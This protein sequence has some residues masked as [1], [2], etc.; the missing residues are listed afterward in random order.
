[1]KIVYLVLDTG[2]PVR[3]S[4]GASAHVRALSEALAE[5]G[6]EITVVAADIEGSEHLAKE[7]Q[8]VPIPPSDAVEALVSTSPERKRELRSLF[9][10]IDAYRSLTNL[11]RTIQPDVVLERLS[12]FSITGLAAARTSKIPYLL[13]VDAPLSDE[14]AQYRGLELQETARLF[15]RTL[16]SEADAVLPVSTALRDWAVSHGATSQRVHVIPNG[17]NTRQFDPA[18]AKDRRKELGLE[19]A[20]VVGFVGGFRPWHGINLIMKAFSLLAEKNRDARLLMV[21]DGPARASVEDWRKKDA[22]TD[23]VVVTGHVPH[24]EVPGFLATMDVVLAPYENIPN[25]YF[26]PLKILESMAMGRPTVASAAGDIPELMMDGKAGIL[27]PPGNAEAL[28]ASA[29]RLLHDTKLAAELG[30]AARECAVSYHDWKSVA[31]T[32]VKHANT[33]GE[34]AH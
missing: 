21:G 27:V 5:I 18:L 30:G 10:N 31:A 3:G 23:R 29:E 4:K 2:I 34:H 33:A 28:A 25:F 19:G 16:V 17:V 1:V 8:L 14:A 22:L 32:I 12:L 24:T 20:E 13:E 7:V 11:I 6:Q 26:S 15:E 9:T